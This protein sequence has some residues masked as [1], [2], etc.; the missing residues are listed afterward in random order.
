M[1]NTKFVTGYEAACAIPDGATVAVGGFC[2]FGSPD[3]VLQGMRERFERTGSPQNI[4]LFKGVSVGD[5]GER[6]VS[7][8][9]LEGL[10][11][12]VICAHVGLEP[13]LARMI[14]EDRCLAYL[15]PLGTITELYRAA[16]SHRPGVMTGTGLETFADPRVEGSK[17]NRRTAEEGGD[18]VSLMTLDGEECLYYPAMPIHVAV[19]RGT[20]ADRQGNVSMEREALQSDQFEAAAAAHNSGG[21]VIVQVERIVDGPLDP[22][23]VVLHHFMVDYIVLAAPEHHLQG[24]DTPEFRPELTGE[25]R[26]GNGV[27][28]GIPPMPLNDRKVCGRRAVLELRENDIINLGIGM[29]DSVAAVAAEEEIADRFTLSIESGVLG[30]VPLSGLGLGASRYPE[31]IYKMADVLNLYDGGCLDMAVL[32]LAE[33]DGHG[34]VNVSSFGGR[35]TGP[36]GFIDIAQHTK[37]VLFVGTFTAGGLRTSYDGGKLTILQEGRSVKFRRQVEQITFSGNYAVRTDKR[38]LAI[39][40]RAVF[41]LTEQGLELIEIAPG[42][43]LERDILA[44]MEFTPIISPDLKEMDPRIFRD[45]PMGLT[46]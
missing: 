28:G 31:A 19:I 38:I 25:V 34:N 8:I 18:I 3:E 15:L 17:A 30:G 40:E 6:G 14:E 26:R 21:I 11:G 4:T 2:G 7:R 33:M 24:F 29:P 13:P 16:A 5:K 35:V 42:V 43:D 41:R 27:S 23:K 10:V 9:A 1:T 46:L 45:G 39:T 32:G 44:H 36:G 12:K 37:T 22:Q 20:T